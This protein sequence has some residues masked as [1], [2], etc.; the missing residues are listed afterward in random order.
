MIKETPLLRDNCEMTVA[1]LSYFKLSHL[2]LSVDTYDESGAS[3]STKKYPVDRILKRR[4]TFEKPVEIIYVPKTDSAT[5]TAL[6]KDCLIRFSL[7]I[8]HCCGQAY[9]GAANMSGHIT[10]VAKRI[11][12]EEPTAIFV[13]CLAHSNNLCLKT[14]GTKSSCVHDALELVMRLSQLIRF[15]PKRST[16]FTTLQEQMSPGAPSL[17]PLCPTRWTVRAKAINSVPKNYSVLQNELEIVKLDKDEYA[18]KARGYLDA[19]D[20]FS[21]FFGLKLSYLIFSATEQLSITLQGVDTTIQEAVSASALAVNYLQKQIEESAYN[22]FYDTVVLESK[23]LT[24][25]PVLPRQRRPPRRIDDGSAP[26]TF[27]NPK[28]FFKQ[29]YNEALDIVI[30]ELKDWFHQTRGMPIALSIEKVLLDSANGVFLKEIPDELHIYNKDIQM[31]RLLIQLQILRDMIKTYNES[32]HAIKVRKVTILRTITDIINALPACKSMLSEVNKL[33]HILLTIPVS[34][35]TA[36]RCFSA[37]RRLKT[38][39]RSS[40]GQERLNNLMLLNIHKD[41]TDTIDIHQIAREFINVN[42]RR[43]NFFGV[44]P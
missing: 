15:S 5:I 36:E 43:Q 17:K 12:E 10:G 31:D 14:L 18:L 11:E 23:D 7:P 25:D 24:A 32:Q 42:E 38:Y 41:I 13:H 30:T 27:P 37:L 1:A 29:M 6:I 16:L 34:S 39:L 9:D 4:E 19:M 26:Y 35:S 28:T 2:S 8:A 3:V 21:N 44:F 20:K 22:T 33:V 40:M